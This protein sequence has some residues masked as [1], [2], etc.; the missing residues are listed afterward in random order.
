MRDILRNRLNEKE[1][2]L[3]KEYTLSLDVDRWIFDA[4]IYVDLAHVIM[5]GERGIIDKEE[6]DKIIK[7]LLEVKNEDIEIENYED[8]HVAIESKIIEKLGSIGGKI[9]TAKSR[10]DEVATCLRFKSREETI[11]IMKLIIDLLNTILKFSKD[12]L[13]VIMPGYTHM[14]HA[15]PILLSHHYLAHYDVFK[16]DL[17]RLKDFYK[18]LNLSPLGSAAFAGTGFK[19]D[20]ERTAYLLGFD[21]IVEHSMDAVST[22]DFILEMIFDV[23]LIMIDVSRLAE[24]LIL[25]STSEFNFIE[26]NDSFASTS[27]IMPQ[28]K[29]PDSLELMRAKSGSLIG[30]LTATLSIC[31]AIPF[32]YN[33]DNQEVSVHLLQSINIVKITLKIL[34]RIIDTLKI[35]KGVMLEES[36]KGFTTATELADIITIKTK[37]P[38]RVAHSIVGEFTKNYNGHKNFYDIKKVTDGLN[39][40]SLKKIGKKLSD[41]GLKSIDVENAL[42]STKNIERR[43]SIGGT[44]HFEVKRM[45]E[46]RESILKKDESEIN[47][48][49][50]KIKGRINEL[51]S[52]C[53]DV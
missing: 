2:E 17:D 51:L 8:V 41:L 25:W 52:I 34:S 5:L 19:I 23:T 31:K 16:R 26:I 27:S 21:D 6:R 40:I 10:N 30:Y 46:E 4:D 48:L 3:F 15:Q 53:K 36:D 1:D 38:F 12:N 9:H 29:N 28:K 14:Q 24:E 11:N 42:N 44:S 20:R 43:T 39:D 49:A 33:L 22:R 50:Q 47:D 35:N 18:R 37:I 13:D 32:S 7:A 45:I